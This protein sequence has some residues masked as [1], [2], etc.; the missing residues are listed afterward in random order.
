MP[1]NSFTPRLLKKVQMS[2]GF[3]GRRAGYPSVGWAPIKMGTRCEAYMVRT[4][5]RVSE[6]A[7]AAVGPFSA[8]C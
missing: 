3:A 5:Q 8:A 2:R 6:R 1:N 4:P 7:N